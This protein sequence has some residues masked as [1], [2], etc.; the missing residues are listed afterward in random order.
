MNRHLVTNVLLLF[1]IV[2]AVPVA[3]VDA[4]HKLNIEPFP[5]IRWIVSLG[6]KKRS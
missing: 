6:R 2:V 3:A 4:V 5:E 1:D